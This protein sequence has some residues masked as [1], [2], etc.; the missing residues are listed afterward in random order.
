LVK[1]L[2]TAIAPPHQTTNNIVPPSTATFAARTETFTILTELKG[3][4]KD[5]VN[6]I[7]GHIYLALLIGKVI[8]STAHRH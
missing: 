5:P 6:Q 8:S 3:H 4:K 1:T 7:L 2:P